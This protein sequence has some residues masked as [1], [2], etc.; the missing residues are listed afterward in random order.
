MKI[1]RDGFKRNGKPYKRVRR[2]NGGRGGGEEFQRSQETS[3]DVA[4]PQPPQ[5]VPSSPGLVNQIPSQPPQPLAM[6]GVNADAASS[7]ISIPSPSHSEHPHPAPPS[8][9]DIPPHHPKAESS[10]KKPAGNSI[11]PRNLGAIPKTRVKMDE[12]V[13]NP[14]NPRASPKTKVKKDERVI[15]VIDNKLRKAAPVEISS[16]EEMENLPS[17]P[18]SPGYTPKFKMA[19]PKLSDPAMPVEWITLSGDEEEV[20]M[21]TNPWD[22]GVEG[23]KFKKDEKNIPHQPR[24]RVRKD[25]GRISVRKDL[26]KDLSKPS[27]PPSM[28]TSSQ[29]EGVEM[30]KSRKD[31]KNI[32]HQPKIQVR[33]DLG[34]IRVRKD[35]GKISVRKDLYKDLST[36]S[37]IPSIRVGE[38]TTTE[39][40]NAM[41]E[42]NEEVS[43]SLVDGEIEYIN[44]PEVPVF[45]PP[46]NYNIKPEKKDKPKVRRVKLVAKRSNH[47][48][49]SKSLL[50]KRRSSLLG[51]KI[52]PKIRKLNVGEK[53]KRDGGEDGKRK[54][55][56][57]NK[58]K[59]WEVSKMN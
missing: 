13:I 33:K 32:P 57:N 56:L 31:E 41:E 16:D 14:S 11:D 59:L 20:A 39:A 17:R 36:P 46:I 5:S 42:G 19:S 30:N 45:P 38:E 12:R 10:P 6:E 49:N 18:P 58:I 27:S 21:E 2:K 55:K 24:I 47:P 48:A 34:K 1:V 4:A 23:N 52:P 40:H 25:L 44:L 29:D 26:Y 3:M 28:E 50:G 43:R 37:S 8:Q 51:K 9:G 53:R 22:E 54:T 7:Q 15:K 35:L